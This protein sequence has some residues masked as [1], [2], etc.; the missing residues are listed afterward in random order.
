MRVLLDTHAFIWWNTS[1]SKLSSQA[2]TLFQSEQ[3]TLLLS[4]ASVWEMQI[5]VQ[6]GKLSLPAPLSVILSKQQAVNAIQLFPIALGHILELSAL[7]D[8]HRDPFDRL[9]VAQARVEN[10]AILTNDTLISQ[11]PVSVIW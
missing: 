7:P 1:S 2:L 5:K 3:D 10:I 6:L 4:L 9:L 11:Y 8:L